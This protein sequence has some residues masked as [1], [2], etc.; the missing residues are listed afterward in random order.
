MPTALPAD[1]GRPPPPPGTVAAGAPPPRR[2][3]ITVLGSDDEDD[4]APPSPAA[5]QEAPR[6]P[7]AE[8]AWWAAL[9]ATA[10]DQAAAA[11]VDRRRQAL[12]TEALPSLANGIASKR[13]CS[14]SERGSRAARSALRPTCCRDGRGRRRGG[15][16]GAG[17][18]EWR[19]GR[20]PAPHLDATAAG[21]LARPRRYARDLLGQRWPG[22][23]T[24]ECCRSN[25]SGAQAGWWRRGST[26]TLP[27]PR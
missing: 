4:E 24:V 21:S 3:L 6:A 17:G 22:Q 14:M 11:D 26:P 7:P 18:R 16:A 13:A 25:G 12:L 10:G 8:P 2:P 19:Q 1:A 9:L 27:G 5:P 23:L 20:R 15:A